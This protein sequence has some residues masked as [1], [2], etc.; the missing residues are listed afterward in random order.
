V[1]VA[2]N[3]DTLNRVGTNAM[4]IAVTGV[5]DTVNSTV[6]GDVV[7]V[8]GA[9]TW[10]VLNL[11]GDTVMS[12]G[13]AVTL[14]GTNDTV[15]TSAATLLYLT[16]S[17][18]LNGSNDTVDMYGNSTLTLANTDGSTTIGLN[19]GASSTLAFGSGIDE[20]QLW[21]SRSGNNLVVTVDGTQEATTISN[22]FNGPASQLG[23]IET[24]SGQAISATGINALV[25]A[26]ASMTAPPAGQTSL[27]AAQQQQLAPVLAA[28][29]H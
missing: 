16:G 5:Y 27:S 12:S 26:M 18:V 4:N 1:T 23:T 11:T 9:G 13:T 21:F 3:Y 29:W 25:Q 28:N 6:A 8:S 10:D 19:S 15:V 7:T 2:G 24:N 20:D 17:A 22:W 14:V